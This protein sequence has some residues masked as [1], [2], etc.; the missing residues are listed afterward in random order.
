[1]LLI[2]LVACSTPAEDMIVTSEPVQ[3]AA[4]QLARPTRAATIWLTVTDT[5]LPIASVAPTNRPT[6]RMTATYQLNAG[7]TVTPAPP[8]TETALEPTLT[9]SRGAILSGITEHTHEIFRRGQQLGNRANVFSKV[10]DS[11]T[12]ATY[13][14]YPIGWGAANLHQYQGLLPVV[15]FFSAA[16]A[17][18]GNSFA[19]ISLSADNGWT[20]RSVFDPAH[21]NPE[22]C[23]PGE[24]PLICE[25][26]IVR[27]AVAL[28]LLGTNDVAEL[29]AEAYR[30]N[31]RNIVTISISRG[32]IPVLSTLP[33]RQGYE[34]QVAEF[35]A[36]IWELA[37][38]YG[39]PLW[40]YGL[41]MNRLPNAGL[42]ADGV[43]PSWPPGDFSAAADF[44]ATNL[45]YGYTLRNLTALLALDILW[46]Q[47]II[48][49]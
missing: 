40:D 32:I 27:P 38:E 44:S 8:Q 46:K 28:V 4:V 37:H 15:E 29:S 25:Y 35:N 23:T 13:A 26:R 48:S 20:T 19:N 10:G 16:N 5:P 18:D 6:A 9:L 14:F 42:S 33:Q 24:M 7:M 39:I 36:V 17:R 22:I 30:A 3:Q 12:V 31:M 45:R 47:V 11:L 49:R 43:H 34:Q 41:A 21:A 2:W 1:M